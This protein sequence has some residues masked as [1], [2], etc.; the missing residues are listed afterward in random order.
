[1]SG[2]PATLCALLAVVVETP[3]ANGLPAPSDTKERMS[4]HEP[5]FNEID[6]LAVNTIRVLSAEAVQRAN[7]GH[8]G[9]PMGCA[10]MAYVLWTRHLR[11]NPANPERLW[12]PIFR[13]FIR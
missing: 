10:P 5:G 1:M 9:M 6:S 4:T 3:A 8:P 12:P 13:R 11:F 2:P 7:S